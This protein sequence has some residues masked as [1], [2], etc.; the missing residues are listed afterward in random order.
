MAEAETLTKPDFVLETFIRTDQDTLWEAIVS[1]EAMAQHHFAFG[2]GAGRADTAEGLTLYTEA[3]APALSHSLISAD[4]KR[5]IDMT[6][7]PKWSETLP[8]SRCTYLIEPH[9]DV[10]KLRIEHYDLPSAMDGAREGWA[11]WASS[12]KTYL[13]TGQPLRVGVPA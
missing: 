7:E 5:R 4:P 12:L 11:R 10:M 9:G 1:G 2:R 6:F 13:E 3:G 8:T